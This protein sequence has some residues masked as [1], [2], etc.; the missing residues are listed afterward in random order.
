MKNAQHAAIPTNP[1]ARLAYAAE[2][3]GVETPR[4]LPIDLLAD[5]GAPHDRV[6]A[7]CNETGTSLDFIY[8]GDIRPMLR[9]FAAAQVF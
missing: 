5:D 9:S 7:F 3:L 2:A 4:E 6:M 1:A 8:S